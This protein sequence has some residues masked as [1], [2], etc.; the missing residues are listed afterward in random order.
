LRNTGSFDL[1]FL[2]RKAS[3]SLDVDVQPHPALARLTHLL[4]LLYELNGSAV[5]YSFAL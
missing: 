2:R 1:E 4:K 3:A 5:V